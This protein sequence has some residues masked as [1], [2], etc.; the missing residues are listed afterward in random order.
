MYVLL[1]FTTF[2]LSS[3]RMY[4]EPITV[5]VVSPSEKQ[6]VII[7]F[8]NLVSLDKI[9][10][11]RPQPR[12]QIIAACFPLMAMK[13]RAIGIDE[14]SLHTTWMVVH[15]KEFKNYHIEKSATVCFLTKDELDPIKGERWMMDENIARVRAQHCNN[16]KAVAQ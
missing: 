12:Q 4:A 2:L 16:I 3:L 5:K 15:L 11:C 9:L 6:E 1:I 10:T 14:K 13:D 8:N 7:K